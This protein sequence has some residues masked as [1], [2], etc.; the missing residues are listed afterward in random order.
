VLQLWRL[1]AG[2]ISHG[3]HREHEFRNFFQLYMELCDNVNLRFREDLLNSNDTE[4]IDL[5]CPGL[6]ILN[7]AIRRAMHWRGSQPGAKSDGPRQR[8]TNVPLT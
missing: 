7:Q 2:T 3:Q 1:G 5:A 4:I 8:L 6:C